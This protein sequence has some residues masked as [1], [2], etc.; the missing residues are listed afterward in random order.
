MSR[1]ATLLVREVDFLMIYSHPIASDR[2]RG[3]KTASDQAKRLCAPPWLAARRLPDRIRALVS[4]DDV[5]G[6]AFGWEVA[7][8]Q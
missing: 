7:V 3:S 4:V 5:V 6:V 2:P 8:L 1:P